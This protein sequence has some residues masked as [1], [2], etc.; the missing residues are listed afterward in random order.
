MPA[1]PL[2]NQQNR[3]AMQ[4]YVRGVEIPVLGFYYLDT[5]KIWLDKE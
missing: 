1:I 3:V 2:Y 4:P 5:R